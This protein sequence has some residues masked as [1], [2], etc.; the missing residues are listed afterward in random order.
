MERSADP[1]FIGIADINSVQGSDSKSIYY[2]KFN[3]QIEK[4]NSDCVDF[5]NS[6]DFVPAP[7]PLNEQLAI[8]PFKTSTR[9][10]LL[11]RPPACTKDSSDE[12]AINYS[13]HSITYE[14]LKPPFNFG[15][16]YGLGLHEFDAMVP[17]LGGRGVSGP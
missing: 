4:P 17:Q 6:V 5:T 15:I 14:I 1:L 12:E 13:A 11:L 2:Q 10:D 8:I 9:V 3:W 16:K 7:S